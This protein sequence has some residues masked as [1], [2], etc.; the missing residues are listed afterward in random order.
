MSKCSFAVLA[1]ASIAAIAVT[2]PAAAYTQLCA[3]PALA[4]VTGNITNGSTCS[5]KATGTTVTEEFIGVSAS[6]T[7][8]LSLG[9]TQIFNNQSTAPST[10]ASQTVTPGQTLNFS[11]T[12]TNDPLNSILGQE[13]V[14]NAGTAYTNPANPFPPFVVQAALPGVYHFAWFS[15]TGAADLDALFGANY[16][17]PSLVGNFHL[18]NFSNWVFVGVEDSRVTADD[19]WN[20][21]IYAFQGVA[22]IGATSSTVPEPSTWAMMLLGF[23]G[24]GYV[25]FRSRRAA[26]AIA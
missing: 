2:Q 1:A 20:D 9:S 3:G 4:G 26:R 21:T 16:I 23:A 10:T 19:D 18:G 14:Y 5:L 7:D 8:I 24:L 12:N 17:P 11:L 13:G 15:V 25:G 22:P 6:D